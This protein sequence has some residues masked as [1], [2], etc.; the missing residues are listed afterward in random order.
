METL[1]VYS[2]HD[3]IILTPVL[4]KMENND[5]DYLIFHI[6]GECKL[7]QG[8]DVGTT[9]CQCFNS[10]VV[11][12]DFRNDCHP[13]GT[14]DIIDTINHVCSIYP[15]LKIVLSGSSSGGWHAF[16]IANIWS[17]W[18][19]FP[20]S[21]VI[22]ICPVSNPAL[23]KVYLETCLHSDDDPYVTMPL[24]MERKVPILSPSV[25]KVILDTQEKYFPK[26][27]EIP[28]LKNLPGHV[29]SLVIAGSYDKNVPLHILLNIIPWV[30]QT[31]IIGKVGH[32]IQSN[33]TDQVLQIIG[34]FL[35]R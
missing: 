1:T 15:N 8:V 19:Q 12:C 10:I 16:Y 22:G 25:A 20:L 6:Q 14:W 5:P 27:D 31:T 11:A 7:E 33:P 29:K 21:T 26:N 9:L 28:E 23:R 2:T 35:E 3:E 30:T 13:H 24:S 32:E 34:D 17:E 18:I 4:I